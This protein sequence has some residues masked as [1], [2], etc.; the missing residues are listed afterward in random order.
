MELKTGFVDYPGIE[1]KCLELAAKTGMSGR[2]LYSSFN[3]QSVL[4]VKTLDPHTPCGLLYMQV[5]IKPW[6]YAARYGMDALHP[7][8]A[9]LRVPELVRE[10]HAH[11][12]EVNP[13]TVDGERELASCLAL[14]ADR[15][16]TNVPDRALAIR[17]KMA[18]GERV[19]L[20]GEKPAE[21]SAERAQ[22]LLVL[23]ELLAEQGF[24]TDE[25]FARVLGQEL[26][27][28]RRSGAVV[29]VSP[30]LDPALTD[31]ALSFRRMG[32]NVRYYLIT[33]EAEQPDWLPYIRR[34]QAAQVEVCYVT[35][36]A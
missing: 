33:Y 1:E 23:Q 6:E 5:M 25:P 20:Y 3:H 14:G 12:L 19:P 31:L 24:D 30:R 27:R 4:R 2:T 29:I 28:V 21:F 7:H 18:A 15:I 16:I 35:P 34:M 9:E 26:R 17:T 22:S 11:H 36:A 8:Y 32:P 10:A 13:W